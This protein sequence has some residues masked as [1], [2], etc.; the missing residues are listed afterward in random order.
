MSCSFRIDEI[1]FIGF[2]RG[3]VYVFSTGFALSADR[4]EIVKLLHG[5]SVSNQ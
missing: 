3:I 2:Q 5:H 4:Q 1:E